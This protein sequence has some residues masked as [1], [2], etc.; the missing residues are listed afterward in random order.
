MAALSQAIRDLSV[1]VMHAK[2][3]IAMAFELHQD[4]Q[5]H[6]LTA[7]HGAFLDSVQ[8]GSAGKLWH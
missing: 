2:P 4:I 6:A 5:R 8:S 7:V 1:Q 3:Q